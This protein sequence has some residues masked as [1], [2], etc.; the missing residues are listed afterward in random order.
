[1]EGFDLKQLTGLQPY[2]SKLFKKLDPLNL[3]RPFPHSNKAK[4][5]E[6]L[7]IE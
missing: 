7:S 5:K 2:I 6:Q 4:I 3:K 1:M